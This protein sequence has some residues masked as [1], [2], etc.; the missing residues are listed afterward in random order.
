MLVTTMGK[1]VMN[2]ARGFVEK[3]RT[4]RETKNLR[5]EERTAGKTPG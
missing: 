2:K 5:G 1:E 4:K 3:R